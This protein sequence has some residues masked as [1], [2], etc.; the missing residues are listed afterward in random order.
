MVNGNEV[1]PIKTEAVD[2]T[3]HRDRRGGRIVAAE[4]WAEL[5]AEYG[6]WRERADS[7]ALRWRAGQLSYV[8]CLGTVIA[9]RLLQ[10]LLKTGRTTFSL[11]RFDPSDNHP[12]LIRSKTEFTFQGRFCKVL[13]RG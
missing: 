12:R 1:E 11:G 6:V 7:S 10:R 2:D 9:P 3:Q 8:G 5:M 4:C 13:R